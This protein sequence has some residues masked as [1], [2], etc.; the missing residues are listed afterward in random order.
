MNM[1]V[2]RLVPLVLLPAWVAGWAAGQQVG[3]FYTLELAGWLAVVL[4]VLLLDGVIYWQHRLFHRVPWLW[5]LHKM[6]HSDVDVDTTTALR[7]HPVEIVLSAVIKC[8]VIVAFGV[9][10]LAVLVFEIILNGTALFN[11]SN[12]RLPVGWDARVRWLLVTPDMHRIHHSVEQGEHNSNF[13]FNLS[14]WDRWFGSY[15]ERPIYGHD[16]M[17]LGLRET[18]QLPT[19][20]VGFMLKQPFSGSDGKE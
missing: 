10:V 9:P 3:L 11:H 2:M 18:N 14:C 8:A 4:S 16:K 6:H 15:T 7:F 20:S 19:W 1:L 12:L 13:G 5:R 17:I